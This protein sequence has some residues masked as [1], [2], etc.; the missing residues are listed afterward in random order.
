M[1]KYDLT[2]K[3]AEDLYDIWAYTVDTWSEE[4][5]ERYYAKLINSFLAISAHP[6][7]YG[8]SYDSIHE[9]LR[10]VHM[11]RHVIFFTKQPSGGALIV[12]ILHERRD[13]KRHL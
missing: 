3:A 9:G 8:Q 2:S 12:R 10:G 5:A 11:G 7:T 13:Y 1:G 4:Q 6:D